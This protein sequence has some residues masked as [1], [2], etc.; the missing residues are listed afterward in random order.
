MVTDAGEA[1][2]T[3]IY[4]AADLGSRLAAEGMRYAELRQV[5]HRIAVLTDEVDVGIGVPVESFHAPDRGDAGDQPLLLEQ[6]QIPVDRGQGDVRDLFADLVEDPVGGRMDIGGADTAQDR[7]P[8]TEMLP[9]LHRHLLFENHS[10]LRP[11]DSICV[12]I[13][14]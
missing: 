13:C 10:C 7:V 4:G 2:L 9:C 14:Q 8:L 3:G 6:G 12:S 5:D 1:E 11:Y